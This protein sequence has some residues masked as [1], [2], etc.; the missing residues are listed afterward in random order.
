MQI[1]RIVR[2]TSLI[3]AGSA[4]LYVAMVA[5]SADSG[6]PA[7]AGG[8]GPSQ[9][10]GGFDAGGLVDVLRDVLS[11]VLGAD[12]IR[13]A[14][15]QTPTTVTGT[16]N[17]VV[18]SEAGTVNSVYAEA[19]FPGKTVEEL[20]DVEAITPARSVSNLPPGYTHNSLSP[21]KWLKPGS[22]AV[23]CG[24]DSAADVL[25]RQVVFILR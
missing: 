16:C 4:T 17:L 2:D 10:S 6:G 8:P 12:A 24:Y 18:R 15:A 25:N 14:N 19:A 13:D 23:L 3:F 7:Q 11:D 22:V 5:C 9:D 21:Y 1:R 20:A